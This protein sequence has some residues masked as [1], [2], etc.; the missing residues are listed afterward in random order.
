[1]PVI[2]ANAKSILF[3]DFNNYIVLDT[4]G[5]QIVVPHERFADQLQ[6]ARNACMWSDG[7]LIPGKLRFG[8]VRTA[9]PKV[10]SRWNQHRSY[11]K[12]ARNP[13]KRVPSSL[14][15]VQQ[16]WSMYIDDLIDLQHAYQSNNK[17]YNTI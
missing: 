12:W 7:H 6:T 4:L 11:T 17:N 15:F 1:M 8:T 3:G 13:G 14:H 2:A 9:Q 16:S 10:A 5:L